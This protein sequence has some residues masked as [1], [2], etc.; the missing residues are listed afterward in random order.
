VG[1]QANVAAGLVELARLVP[2]VGERDLTEV[3]ALVCLAH[4]RPWAHRPDDPTGWRQL[5]E[6]ARSA[7]LDDALVDLLRALH[8]VLVVAGVAT[9]A[10][11]AEVVTALA[12][13]SGI[14][15]A[16]RPET[17]EVAV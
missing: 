12:A 2:D 4:A 8:R 10:G 11:R 6:Q 9:P 17:A 15:S 5:A 14:L 13:A 16:C 3:H 1:R 7:D